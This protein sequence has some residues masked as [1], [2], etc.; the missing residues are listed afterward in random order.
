MPAIFIQVAVDEGPGPPIKYPNAELGKLHQ[1]VA[2]LVRCTD[3][4]ARCQS[5]NERSATVL[6]NVYA[7]PHFIGA[8][9][10]TAVAAD[11]STA[12]A[13]AVIASPLSL[14]ANDLLYTRVS[15]TKKLLEDASA[16]EDGLRL[17]Q[18]CCW[19]NPI[20]SRSVLTELLWLCSLTGHHLQDMRH[21]TELLLH[22]LLMEDSWQHHRIHNALN[23]VAEEREGLLTIID[24]V[25]KNYPRRAYQI[26][27][28]LVQL[29]KQSRVATTMLNTSR[30]VGRHWT[31]AVEWL[32]ESLE[33]QRN[34]GTTFAYSSW[35]PPGVQSGYE[36]SN[37]GSGGGGGG[38][39][40]SSSSYMLE[41][42]PSTKNTLRLACELCPD[43]EQEEPADPDDVEQPLDDEKRT[44]ALAAIAQTI[45]VP[46]GGG[47]TTAVSG[48]DDGKKVEEETVVVSNSSIGGRQQ[49]PHSFTGSAK[50][51]ATAGGD[52]DVDLEAIR[53]LEITSTKSTDT[54]SNSSHATVVLQQQQSQSDLSL[55][56]TTAPTTT[57]T[58]GD[59]TM[60]TSISQYSIGH[61]N[62]V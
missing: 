35:S 25:K 51:S 62:E 15:Y 29:F 13:V 60:A 53:D 52:R 17:L 7:D 39:G 1:V 19:E 24:R 27:K 49:Q 21:H 38:G 50:Q 12:P 31:M 8:A 55:A 56:S 23:G 18:F 61:T 58:G 11:P 54:S 30:E 41:R 28:L 44:A 47:G 37:A 32:Q 16:G 4:T 33:R 9:A 20:F 59:K 46:I 26:V 2:M 6:P 5:S 43:E 34:V 36:N 57:V 48:A 14:V 45:S 42:T 40:G 22:V 10:A 3:V